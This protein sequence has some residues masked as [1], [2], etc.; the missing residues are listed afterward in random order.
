VGLKDP[1]LMMLFFYSVGQMGVSVWE[2][3]TKESTS[4]DVIFIFSS[5]DGSES[6]G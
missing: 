1:T 2:S 5:S 3:R 6:M 4:H